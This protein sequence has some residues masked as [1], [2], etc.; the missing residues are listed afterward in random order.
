[1]VTGASLEQS[2][3]EEVLGTTARFCAVPFRMYKLERIVAAPKEFT[4]V[5]DVCADLVRGAVRNGGGHVLVFLPGMDQIQRLRTIIKKVWRPNDA[6]IETMTLH[7]DCLG[8]GEDEQKHEVQDVRRNRTLVILSS[9]IAARGVTL[10]D[11]KY[12]FMQPHCRKT[13]LH[14]SGCD[15]LGNEVVDAELL[16]NMAGRAGRTV[17]GLVFYLFEV[18]GCILIFG[19]F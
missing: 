6:P 2:F 14:Q 15:V 10:P 4:Q 17:P 7:S 12:V 9:V 5:L 1:M 13:L 3:L 8:L 11:I 18:E 16:A 19:L